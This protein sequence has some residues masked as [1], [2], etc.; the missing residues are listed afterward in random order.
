MPPIPDEHHCG[1]AV[2]DEARLEIELPLAPEQ[3]LA[4]SCSM[5]L[6][7]VPFI[8]ARSH[9]FLTWISSRAAARAYIDS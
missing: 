3:R 1:S 4:C 6:R 7:I 2:V 8:E 9:P 5:R